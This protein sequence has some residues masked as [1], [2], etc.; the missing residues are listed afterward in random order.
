MTTTEQKTPRSTSRVVLRVLGYSLYCLVLL[1]SLELCAR[2]FWWQRGVRFFHAQK[3]IYYSFYPEMRRITHAPCQDCFD[4][5]LLGASVL[6]NTYGSVEA[7]LKEDLTPVSGKQIRVDNIAMSAQTSLDSYYKYRRLKDKHYDVVIDYDGI[8]EVRTNAVPPALFRNDY[9]HYSWYKTVNDFE[10]NADGRWLV[11][12]YTLEFAIDSYRNRV[13]LDRDGP[14]K[15]WLDYGCDIKSAGPFRQNTERIVQIAREKHEPVLLMSLSYYIPNG[16]TE[17]KFKKRALD[18]ARH[19]YPV[20]LLGKPTCVAAGID[21]H[22]AVIRDIAKRY[23]NVLFV[24]QE[25]LM[26]H[27]GV[28]FNDMCHLTTRGCQRFVDN[29]LSTITRLMKPGDTGQSSDREGK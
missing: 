5:L 20:E 29:M 4:I 10:K 19:L 13:V 28:Y 11:L 12:P 21:A 22:N 26:P 1:A 27:E 3:E 23:D 18:Y 2:A 24:D 25:R 6:N 8:N 7:V 17:A 15:E 9:S 16:Y 14:R